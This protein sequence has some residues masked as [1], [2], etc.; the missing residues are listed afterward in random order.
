M[1]YA[2]GTLF[3]LDL[4]RRALGDSRLH[5]LEAAATAAIL[6]ALS[7][8]QFDEYT[9]FSFG[10][11]QHVLWSAL[12]AGGVWLG[13]AAAGLY[14]AREE[15]RFFA[16]LQLLESGLL[17]LALEHEPAEMLTALRRRLNFAQYGGNPAAGQSFATR[18]QRLLACYPACARAVGYEAYPRWT[19]W[20]EAGLAWLLLILL[21]WLLLWWYRAFLRMPEP[22]IASLFAG[23]AAPSSALRPGPFLL[24]LGALYLARSTL[25]QARRTGLMLALVDVLHG[26]VARGRATLA[27]R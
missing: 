26:D 10:T 5:L 20:A 12:I 2:S 18:M 13:L 24:L 16:H 3:L 15:C 21:A 6:G 19:R 25:M 11:P 8:A 1:A 14:F 4:H 22:D 17:Y 7:T 23:G 9:Y 27:R